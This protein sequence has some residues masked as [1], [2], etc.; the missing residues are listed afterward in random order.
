M[1]ASFQ[2]R[3]FAKKQKD[4]KKDK[5]AAEKESIKEEF[6][7]VD[8]DDIKNQFGD[9]LTEALDE[10]EDQLKTVK[11]DRASNDIFDDIEV[12]AYGEFHP[13]GDLCQTIVRGNQILTVKVFDESVKDEVLK[14]LTR[15][16][17]DIEV[18]MEGKDIRVKM[19][20]G[21]KEHVEQAMKKIKEM[22]DD[23]KKNIR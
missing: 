8:T 11:S 3:E 14:A 17:M 21:K 18:Q 9:T 15:S 5:K 1:I 13:F 20:L 23:A 7:E 16:N 22:G 12:K 10:L 19:G 4:T 2:I 6:A